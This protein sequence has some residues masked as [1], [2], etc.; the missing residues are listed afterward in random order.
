[1]L[2]D[3]FEQI[4]YEDLTD[5]LR[6]I[7]DAMGIDV[8]RNLMKNLQGVYFY[9][10]RVAHLDK[11]ILRYMQNN[12]DKTFKEIALDLGVSTQYLWK[13]RSKLKKR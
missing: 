4:E 10:P 5:D 1:M 6:L 12:P 2:N 11:F 7:A 13:I 9:V 8:L 3:I